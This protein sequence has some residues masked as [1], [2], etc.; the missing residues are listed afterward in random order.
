MN[1]GFVTLIWREF[2]HGSLRKRPFLYETTRTWRGALIIY[3]WRFC[4]QSKP[5]A[6]YRRWG[7]CVRQVYSFNQRRAALHP[8]HGLY[9]EFFLDL[10][11]LTACSPSFLTSGQIKHQLWISG[12]SCCKKWSTVYTRGKETVPTKSTQ[13]KGRA[14]G[15]LA[16]GSDRGIVSQHAAVL[17]LKLQDSTQAQTRATPFET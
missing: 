5:A 7:A 9:I 10:F 11:F 4:L 2:A 6:N 16:L 1:L 14:R 17:C 8:E 3:R 15:T 13:R 12:C